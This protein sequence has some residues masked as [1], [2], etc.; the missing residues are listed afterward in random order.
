MLERRNREERRGMKK[1]QGIDNKISN[2]HPDTHP[3]LGMRDETHTESDLLEDDGCLESDKTRF[4][5]VKG[6]ER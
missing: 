1:E 3:F 5:S 6:G 4:Q 2:H